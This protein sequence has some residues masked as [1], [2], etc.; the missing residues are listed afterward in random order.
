MYSVQCTLYSWLQLAVLSQLLQCYSVKSVTS[1][2]YWVPYPAPGLGNKFY[3]SSTSYFYI[4]M[5]PA[6]KLCCQCS[7]QHSTDIP[8]YRLNWSRSRCREGP[9]YGK[10]WSSWR[11]QI[12]ALIPKCYFK[13]LGK[14]GRVHAICSF[15][16]KLHNI[17]TCFAVEIL[18]KLYL[19]FLWNKSTTLLALRFFPPRL[20]WKCPLYI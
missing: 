17:Y 19:N 1:H 10:H 11:V 12:V 18:H 7:T 2:P 5:P 13:R 15:I 9:E 14:G 8:T 3:R 4:E 6:F 20:L 16:A